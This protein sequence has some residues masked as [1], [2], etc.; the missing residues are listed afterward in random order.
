VNKKVWHAVFTYAA[1]SMHSRGG[2][3]K[4]S[5]I[6]SPSC[7][8]FGCDGVRKQDL[9]YLCRTGTRKDTG[10]TRLAD[11]GWLRDVVCRWGCILLPSIGYYPG[12]SPYCSVWNLTDL[13]R[14]RFVR[15]GS[16][17]PQRIPP[18]EPNSI[19]VNQKSPTPKDDSGSP[20]ASVV[21]TYTGMPRN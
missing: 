20:L 15:N 7:Y 8:R 13:Y 5:T 3:P 16:T 2:D 11:K 9:Q 6:S 1:N 4:Y 17:V 18:I 21:G 14:D 12:D 19:P 10:C